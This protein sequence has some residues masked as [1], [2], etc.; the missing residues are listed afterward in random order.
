VAPPGSSPTILLSKAGRF[1]LGPFRVRREL[2]RGGWGVVFL[3][4]D[5]RLRRRVALKV[6]RPEVLLSPG[7]QRRFLREA[8]AAA[9]LDH[10]NL[11]PVFEAGEEGGVCYIA[12]AYCPGPTL[13]RWLLGRK[14]LVPA[15][16]A[17]ALVAHLAEGVQDAP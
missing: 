7:L 15:R 10:P 17:A 11:V 3:A 5:R 16:T 6:P 14:E 13:A 12:S 1:T 9:G 2:G 8:R 4:W